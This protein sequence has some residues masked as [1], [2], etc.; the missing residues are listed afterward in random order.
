MSEAA[1][2]RILIQQLEPAARGKS[3]IEIRD[4]APKI[5]VADAEY[6]RLLGYPRGHEPSGRA[7][8]L[9][10][11]ARE[12]YATNGRP[13]IYA[14]ET[15]PVQMP[16][17]AIRIA[18][19][20]FHSERLRATFQEAE[21]TGAVLA[22]VSAGPEA[23]AEAQKLWRE[24]KPD[25]YFFLETFASAVTEHL[26][27][28]LGARLCAVR[29]TARRS[30]SA[31]LQPR[32]YGLGCGR[33]AAFAFAVGRK[34]TGQTGNAG[35]GRAASQEIAVGGFRNHK[36]SR[37]AASAD[38]WRPVPQLLVSPVPVSPGSIWTERGRVYRESQGF[39]TL[40]G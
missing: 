33:A 25:E 31:A 11:W 6:M 20:A 39:A 36:R 10:D 12:W 35:I 26:I 18:G 8:E 34:L 2:M 5:Q 14:R 1:A 30:D 32:L 13:W 22:A 40:G 28:Q 17:G 16:P 4:L 15:A 9:A 21:A 27:M 3:A 38:R 19:A 29:R 23:E 37:V 24:E 7:R